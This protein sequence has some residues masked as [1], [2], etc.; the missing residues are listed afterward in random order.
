QPVPIQM[1]ADPST[2]QLTAKVVTKTVTTTDPTTGQP[3]TTVVT[4]TDAATLTQLGINR[5]RYDLASAT[6]K[7]APG[8]LT[9]A[10]LDKSWA[11]SMGN[12]S[13]PQTFQV[14]V[15]GPTATLVLP[16]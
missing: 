12:T 15:T 9:I 11:D 6:T 4:V 5:F 13:L 16:Q 1:V 10:F 2:G 14:D 7:Y 3:V 8:H